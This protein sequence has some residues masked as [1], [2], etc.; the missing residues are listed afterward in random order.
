M[1]IGFVFVGVLL[2]AGALLA[3]GQ[4]AYQ[5]VGTMAEFMTSMV[6]PNSND[7]LLSI[8]RGGPQNDKEW[9]ALQKSAVALAEAGNLL[10]MRGRAFQ[11]D[12]NKDAKM[13]VDAGN[14][15]YKAAKAKDPKALTDL[16]AQIDASC[17]ACHKQYRPNVYPKQ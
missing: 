10:I 14:A 13:L 16:S 11:G 9:M 17:T 2:V 6:H 15:T 8:T 4:D 5:P 7:I 3:Q 1:R 12:W